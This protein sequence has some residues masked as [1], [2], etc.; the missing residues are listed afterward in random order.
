M[1]VAWPANQRTK[2]DSGY[3]YDP[4]GASFHRRTPRR[5]V[6]SWPQDRWEI[7]AHA[8]PAHSGALG[9]DGGVGNVVFLSENLALTS[10]FTADSRHHSGQFRSFLAQRRPYWLLLLQRFDLFPTEN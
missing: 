9:A 3:G 8:A 5:H 1:S 7:F 10:G 2:P 6:L 4:R